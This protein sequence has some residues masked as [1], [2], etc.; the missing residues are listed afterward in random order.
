MQRVAVLGHLTAVLRLGGAGCLDRGASLGQFQGRG[1]AD[2]IAA[3]DQG[4]AFLIGIQSLLGNPEQLPVG[5][6]GEIAVG[7]AG[8]EADLDTAL[9]RLA[10]EKFLQRLFAEAAQSTE[11]VQLPGYPQGGKILPAGGRFAGGAQVLRGA[12]AVAA[13]IGGYRRQQR[14]MLDAVKGPVGLHIQSRDA[15]IPIVLQR[16]LDQF[17][18]RRVPE[19]LLPAQIHR[20]GLRIQFAVGFTGRPDVGNRHRRPL[21]LRNHRTTAEQAQHRQTHQGRFHCAFSLSSVTTLRE[22]MDDTIT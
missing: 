22:K 1:N 12:A 4:Q 9:S 2:V 19:E 7:H 16:N 3:L 10:G 14:G 5:L 18:Q 21:V 17:A 6:P 11:Q 8:D 20:V 13:G 15:H